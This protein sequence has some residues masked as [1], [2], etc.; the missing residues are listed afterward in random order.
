MA[1]PRRRARGSH[2]T[3]FTAVKTAS[4]HHLT[5][6]PGSASPAN[7]PSLFTVHRHRGD[8]G[9]GIARART[10]RPAPGL[11]GLLVDPR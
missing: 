9:A 11:R 2:A 8:D 3:P 4:P 10:F 1:Q 7:V 6:R 5:I